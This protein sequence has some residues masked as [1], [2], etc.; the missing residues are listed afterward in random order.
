MTKLR[1]KLIPWVSLTDPMDPALSCR[2]LADTAAKGLDGVLNK[3]RGAEGYPNIHLPM[4][5][6]K[7]ADAAIRLARRTLVVLENTTVNP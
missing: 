6:P 1:D 5:W 7:A 3:F 4:N 2:E